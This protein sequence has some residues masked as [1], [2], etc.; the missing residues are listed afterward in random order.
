M[1]ETCLLSLLAVKVIILARHKTPRTKPPKAKVGFT[2]E[3]NDNCGVVGFHPSIHYWWLYNHVGCPNCADE[4][5]L[6]M[7]VRRQNI[8]DQDEPD[9][10]DGSLIRSVGL[11]VYRNAFAD[12]S[13]T[14][15][16]EFSMKFFRRSY[17]NLPY[18]SPKFWNEKRRPLC[19][20]IADM[21]HI[22]PPQGIDSV[23][24]SPI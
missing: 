24:S 10:R 6:L 22:I 20:C 23:Y 3:M 2:R 12:I 1:S 19:N 18:V 13:I 5:L 9:L 4:I 14:S 17:K 11:H 8:V 7:T 15:A 16:V 21:L